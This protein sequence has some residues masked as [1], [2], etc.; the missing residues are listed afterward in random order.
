[1]PISDGSVIKYYLYYKVSD[2]INYPFPILNVA[3]MEFGNE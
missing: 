3:A 1:M 2:E